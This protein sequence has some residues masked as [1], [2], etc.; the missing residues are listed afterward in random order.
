MKEVHS[1]L[2]R[3]SPVPLDEEQ[4]RRRIEKQ[5]RVVSRKEYNSNTWNKIR[6]RLAKAYA[7]L[8]NRWDDVTEKLTHDYTTPYDDVFLED[9]DSGGMLR[10]FGNSRNIVAM[11][12]RKTVIA[13]QRQGEKN[14]CLVFLVPPGE[15]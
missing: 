10:Q 3:A 15:H 6:Q 13:F 11:S 12:W 14:R 4:D 7:R 2:N 5:H 8:N 9:L 1:R